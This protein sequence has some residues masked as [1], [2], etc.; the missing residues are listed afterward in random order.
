VRIL[1]ADGTLYVR[2]QSNWV[3]TATGVQVLA[4]QQ[5]DAD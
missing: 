1:A 2:R 3:Q 5:G 4:T